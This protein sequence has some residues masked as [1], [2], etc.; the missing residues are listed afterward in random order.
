MATL[1]VLGFWLLGAYNRLVRLRQ[2][3]VHAFAPVDAQ[4]KQR[5]ELLA[6]LIAASAAALAD[7]PEAGTAV[8]AARRQARGA[9]EH[10]AQRPAHAGRLASLVLAE[11]V[12]Q[13]ALTR[14]VTLLLAR[15][16]LRNDATLRALLRD[17]SASQ[18]R[19][20][21]AGENFNASVLEYNRNVTQFPTT[22][23]A[24]LFGFKKAG[25]L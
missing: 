17:L 3:V 14:L 15:P 2:T 23:V 22:L 13:S 19:I 9:A 21:A 8:E 4:C 11:Q 6:A 5:H 20:A 25:A 16:A 7:A 12:L 1:A 24:A 18:H 10:A